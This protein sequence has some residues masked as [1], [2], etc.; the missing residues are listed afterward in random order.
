VSSPVRSKCFYEASGIG[1]SGEIAPP[2]GKVWVVTSVDVYMGSTIAGTETFLKSSAT[3]G[4]WY[5]AVASPGEAGYGHYEGR[6]VFS[7]RGFEAE[8]FDSADVRVSGFELTD[9]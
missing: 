7:D 4:A 2:A 5:R 9:E 3:G 6:Q 8:C 1:S